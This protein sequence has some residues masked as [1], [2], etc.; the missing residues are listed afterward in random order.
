MIKVIKILTPLVKLSRAKALLVWCAVALFLILP[1]V[2][3]AQLL[4]GSASPVTWTGRINRSDIRPGEK[5]DLLITA[6]MEEPWHIYSTTQPPGGPK[7]TRISLESGSPFVA[8]GPCLQPQPIRA[9][10]PNFDITAELYK[11]EV[12]FTLPIAVPATASPGDY[13]VTAK[14]VYMACTDK[15][16][17]PPIT[18]PVQVKATVVAGAARQQFRAPADVFTAGST[19]AG[20][21]NPPQ[22]PTQAGPTASPPTTTPGGE[23]QKAVGTAA[24]VEQARSQGIWAFIWLAM[25]MGALSLLT[26][27][28]FPMIPITVSYF[29]GHAQSSRKAGLIQA[30]VYSGGIIFTFTGLG[31]GLA[32]LLGATGINQFAANPWVNLVITAIFIG[33]ALNL[34]GLFQIIVPSGVLTKLSAKSEKGGYI[35]TLLMGL[36]FTL[37]SFTCTVPFV[38]TVLLTTAQGEWKWPLLGMLAF[39]TVFAAPFFVLA[40]VPQWMAALPKSGGW[41][42]SVKVTM[43]FLEIAA[44]MK[45]LSNVDLVWQWQLITREVVLAVWLAVC[46]LTS[47]YLLGK[48]QLPHD[49]PA[50]KIGVI[51]M[52]ASLSFLAMAFYLFTG[53][54][55]GPLGELDAFLPPRTQSSMAQFGRLASD[56]KTLHWIEDYEEGLRQAR[57]QNKLVFVNFTGYAC[58]N[59]RWMETNIF[60]LPEVRRELEKFVLVE[61]F[62]DGEGERF[63]RNR[64]L[65]SKKFGT[66]A[67]PFYAILDGEGREIATFPSLTRDKDEFIRFLRRGSATI[68]QLERVGRAQ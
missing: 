45:F 22:A 37:T 42:N 2:I 28:V 9:F 35:G 27:C 23:T 54:I 41:L 11:K 17:L 24:E 32:I 29:T 12:T 20:S 63:E 59:C 31:L 53:L 7:P 34:F 3:E 5:V 47:V 60:P 49:S 33:F 6:K 38:G 64:E 26:P 18:V 36:T 44:A 40:V 1:A 66:I 65:E 57:A 58:T 30:L 51:R 67:L 43:G 21:N 25:T 14:V 62:T 19:A 52:L 55:G 61:L 48:F 8:A 56:G 15:Q 46:V 50:E 39:S 10:D 4:S 68:A 16:C 13:T